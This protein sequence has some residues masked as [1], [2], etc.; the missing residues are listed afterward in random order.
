MVTALIGTSTTRKPPNLPA[1]PTPSPISP[2]LAHCRSQTGSPLAHIERLTTR[3]HHPP[4]RIIKTVKFPSWS[5]PLDH[6]DE[7]AHQETVSRDVVLTKTTRQPLKVK[8]TQACV[9]NNRDHL[10]SP[11][12]TSTT[13]C[14]YHLCIALLHRYDTAT[15]A[16]CWF[17]F[18]APP[19][20]SLPSI[21]QRVSPSVTKVRDDERGWT[22]SRLFV[23]GLLRCVSP[24]RAGSPRRR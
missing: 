8:T 22:H 1:S 21:R 20:C 4:A 6:D 13:R 19:V 15:S 7:D 3:L 14:L 11:S 24:R 12:R 18:V 10:Y 5:I 16:P 2:A 17:A 23:R 9:N